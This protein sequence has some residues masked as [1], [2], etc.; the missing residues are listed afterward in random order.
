MAVGDLEVTVPQD[1]KAFLKVH[2]ADYTQYPPMEARKPT[3][4]VEA[5]GIF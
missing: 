3:H 5:S 2:Y 1:Y 4:S